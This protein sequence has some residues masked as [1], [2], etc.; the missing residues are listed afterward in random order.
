MNVVMVDPHDPRVV[1]AFTAYMTEVLAVC[2]MNG[3]SL[4]HAVSEVADY[5]PPTGAFLAVIDEEAIAACVALR[6][7]DATTGEIKRMWVSPGLRGQGVGAALLEA[8]EA[9]AVELGYDTLRLDTHE[10]LTAAVAMYTSHGYAE[11]PNYN[12]NPDAT[13]FFEKPLRTIQR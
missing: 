9:R 10:G 4:A 1:Y 3:V 5:C 7:L 11:I 2:G 12:D 6:R 8:V 13:H